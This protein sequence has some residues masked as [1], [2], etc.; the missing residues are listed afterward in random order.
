MNLIKYGEKYFDEVEI[1]RYHRRYASVSAEMNDV[2]MASMNDTTVWVIRG[3]SDKR[4]GIAVVEGDKEEK[5]L[6]G[7]ELAYKLSKTNEPD[8]A[9][10]SFPDKKQNYYS[11]SPVD[12]CVKDINPD[13]LIANTIKGITEILNKD[14]NAVVAGS[15]MGAVWIENSVKNSHGIEVTQRDGGMY[16]YIYAIGRKDGRVTPGIIELD[17]RREAFVDVDFVVNGVLEKLKHAY[18]MIQ[19]DSNESSLIFEP[20]ALAEL[21]TYALYPAFR[22]E[23]C[24]KETSPLCNKEGEEIMSE[25]ITITDDPFHPK[26]LNPLIA[27]DEGVA[28]RRHV[29]VERGIFKGFLWDNYWGKI[30]GKDSTGHGIRTLKTGAINIGAHNMV[31]N[32]G[33]RSIEDIIGDM[34]HGYIVSSLQG[35]HSSNPDTGDFAVVANPAFVVKDGKIVGSTVLMLSGNVYSILKNVEEISKESRPMY[36]I[37]RGV[38]PYVLFRDMKIA[39][40]SR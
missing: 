39:P 36:A 22:G 9:W 30:S 8:S 2:S 33:Q 3:V 28:T 35:A 14:S 6:K 31:I 5:V 21:F 20:L 26:S 38:Y 10:E 4:M 19:A 1:S 12:E 32:E 18:N 37:A 27:D 17:A 7:I 25:S 23:R 16:Y 29:I 40:V 11:A 24:V 13:E 15:E 34:K